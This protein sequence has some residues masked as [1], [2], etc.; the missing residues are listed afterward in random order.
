MKRRL[1]KKKYLGKFEAWYWRLIFDF[2]RQVSVAEI[3]AFRKRFFE[4][5]DDNNLSYS[6]W[7]GPFRGLFSV[8]GDKRYDS[9]TEAQRQSITTWLLKQQEVASVSDRPLQRFFG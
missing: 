8:Y 4:L 3:I 2:H 6:G 9:V 1:R 5:L 7:S